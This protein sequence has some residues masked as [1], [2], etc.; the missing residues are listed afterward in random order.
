MLFKAAPGEALVRFPGEVAAVSA[1][2]ELEWGRAAYERR[3]WADAHTRLSRAAAQALLD[4]DDLEALAT[5]AYLRPASSRRA[6][7]MP[8]QNAQRTVRS[9]RSA[10][11]CRR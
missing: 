11:R 5:S 1:V 9:A 7:T 3:A 4:A 8:T 6:R 10:S 2:D